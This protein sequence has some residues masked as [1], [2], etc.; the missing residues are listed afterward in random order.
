MKLLLIGSGG[1]EHAL[2][3]KFAQSKKVEKIFVAPG[4]GGTAIENKCENVNITDIDE[5][6]KFAQNEN[7]DLTVVGPE[8]PLTKGI[9]NKFKKEGLKIFGP[10]ENGAKLEG[11]KSFSKE[12]MKKYGVKTAQYETFTNV[13]EAL[14]YLEICEYP[15][16]VKADGLAAGKGVA[17]CANKQEAEEAVKSYMVEDIFN[18]AG[19]TI[20]IEEFLEGV[21]AS[22]LSITDGKTI[23]PFI[24]GKDHKQIFDGGKGPNTGGMGVLAPNPYVTEEVM[25]EFEENI[26]A[27]TLNGIKEEGFD[28]KGIIFFGIMITKKGTYLLEYNVRMGDP[29]T[30]S[31][32]YLME[33]DLVEVIEA[34]L[35]E[36]LDKIEIKWK[37]G[38]CINVVLA[39]K[40]YP[41]NFTR[42]YEIKIDEKVKDK[43]FLA[44]AKFENG[45][46]KTNGGRVLSVIGLGKDTE[47]ARKDAYN[48][49]KYVQFE[50]AYCRTDIGTHM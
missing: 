36:E 9:V 24:S 47:E 8:D 18:G 31:V 4:N 1:R 41:G 15:T 16:V 25:K 37:D 49:I 29:E 44:G 17:I 20:V 38:V 27:K 7:V 40:G 6:V 19:Q 50:G 34:A 10:A 21:E 32:L 42:G 11:S 35:R 12:F 2:A 22:I 26:M 3:W 30:Q 14:K 13:D 43:V 48:N 46:L 39:S 23:I 28:Y 45:I 33:S 5:L